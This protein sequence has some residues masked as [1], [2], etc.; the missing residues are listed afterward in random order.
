MYTD[1]MSDAE[2]PAA[3]LQCRRC[4]RFL[5]ADPGGSSTAMVQWRGCDVC[6]TAL[7]AQAALFV[8]ARG[9]DPVGNGEH[10]DR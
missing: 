6:H 10:G 7:F 4:H 3:T 5:P 9:V 2:Q 1:S 8:E